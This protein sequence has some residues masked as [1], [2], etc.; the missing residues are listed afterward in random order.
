LKS[1]A[2]IKLKCK[3][4]TTTSFAQLQFLEKQKSNW[5]AGTKNPTSFEERP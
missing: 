4:W 5:F 1:E 2:I 3:S